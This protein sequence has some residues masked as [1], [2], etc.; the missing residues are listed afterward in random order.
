MGKFYSKIGK[1]HKLIALL[2]V[3][4]LCLGLVCAYGCRTNNEGN[5]ET[6]EKTANYIYFINRDKTRIQAEEFIFTTDT[7]PEQFQEMAKALASTPKHNECKTSLGKDFSI[8]SYGIKDGNL[9][10]N[11]DAAY[12]K[13]SSTEEILVRAALVRSFVQSVD[14]NYVQFLVDGESLL[15]AAGMA[16][17]YLNADSFIEND[18]K[19]INAYERANVTLY[20]ATEDG[21]HLIAGQR[22]V[23]YNT[24]VS[25][26]KMV[27]EQLIKGP[28]LAGYYPTINPETKILS[29]T[30]KDG[31]CYVNLSEEFLKQPYDVSTDVVIYSIANSLIDLSS[32]SRVQI[33]VGGSSKILYRETKSLEDPIERNLDILQKEA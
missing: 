10:L 5:S 4:V 21:E 31:T 3:A 6:S 1:L 23:I 28:S 13:L 18:G 14:I 11:M 26:E 19:E 25:M 2:L 9:I 30:N 15:D 22:Q 27:M 12:K 32:V 20:F 8:T 7:A 33:Q 24:N 16:V 17:G 29:V